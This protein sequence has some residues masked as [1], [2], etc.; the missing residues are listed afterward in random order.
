VN[1]AIK[2]LT[3]RKRALESRSEWLRK[4]LRENMALTGIKR[5]DAID[6]T[7]SARL[8]IG[9]DESVE[10]DPDVILPDALCRVKVEADKSRIKAAIKAGEP[11]PDG[12]RIVRR[13]RLVIG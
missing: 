5:I 3:N 6:G 8:E 9:R 10:I 1:A 12:V 11:V 13:D 4:Y 2:R 7:F